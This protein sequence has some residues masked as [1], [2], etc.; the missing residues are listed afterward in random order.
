MKQGGRFLVPPGN[1]QKSF[2]RTLGGTRNR[3]PV[4]LRAEEGIVPLFHLRNP[5]PFHSTSA[6][7]GI[8]F[9][10]PSLVTVM[11][12]HFVANRHAAKISI[13]PVTA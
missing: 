8:E 4:S 10:A 6:S 7:T 9:W 5:P 1:T 2:L 11:A 12:L 3:P 13:P